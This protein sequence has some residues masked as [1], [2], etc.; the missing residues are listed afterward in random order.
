MP[1]R[2]S[3]NSLHQSASHRLC[4]RKPARRS[5]KSSADGAVATSEPRREER[6]DRVGID[7]L[8]DDA[9]GLE[10]A[11][12]PGA[13]PV[14]VGVGLHEVAVRAHE[15]RR[16]LV[17][18]VVVPRLEVRPVVEQVGAGV[19]VGGDDEVPIHERYGTAM[20]DLG[21]KVAVVTG[22]GG[23]IGR[24]L[25]ERFLAEGMKVV[26]ADIDEPLLDATVARAVGR[27]RTT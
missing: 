15:A 27:A 18:L 8:G 13:V 22:G 14:A 16:P 3:G 26:L 21:G 11:H 6:R 2:R 9:V 1:A 19:T 24:A 17:E 4:A 12:A 20:Q 25:G 7:D 5:S 23:G 10:L